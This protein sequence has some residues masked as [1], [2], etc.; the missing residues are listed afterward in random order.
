MKSGLKRSNAPIF[1][2]LFGAGG[3]LSALFGPALVFITGIAVPFGFM[4]PADAMSYPK[5]LAFAQNFI[6]KGFI[7]AV[8][9]LFLWFAA[10]R[11]Y[12]SLHEVGIHAGVGAKLVCYGSA[13]IATVISVVVLLGL[14][15]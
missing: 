3:M 6:G 12:H 14:G 7:L 10:H 4:L 1:W 5:M 15:F 8:I 11:I 9:A 2:S 13:F